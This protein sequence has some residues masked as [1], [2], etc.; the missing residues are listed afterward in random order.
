M[1]I[2]VRKFFQDRFGGIDNKIIQ[3][4]KK[5]YKPLP[6]HNFEH[7]IQT[8]KN[9]EI[10]IDNY[11]KE[12][13]PVNEKVVY[14]AC[15]FHDAG[16]SEDCFK[17]GFNS[18]EEYSAFLARKTLRG[19]NEEEKIIDLV[20]SCILATHREGFFKSNEEKIVRAADL[21]EMAKGYDVFL[22]NNQ[23][24][25]FEVKSMTGKE[26]PWLEWKNKTK[27]IVEFYLSQDIRLTSA[28]DTEQGES[29]FHKMVKMNLAK[30]LNEEDYP[31]RKPKRKS[32]GMRIKLKHSSEEKGKPRDFGCETRL[33][34]NPFM[35]LLANKE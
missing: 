28:H 6:Y 30:F 23:K 22:S 14:C 27:D 3:L 8:V 2:M 15:I 33:S 5:L 12:A 26:I 31:K 11:R 10:I 17:E 29:V 19:F 1:V 24:L 21:A 7:V 25:Y 16:Y 9:A 32:L 18:K 34:D 35:D 13:V 20:R 4:A